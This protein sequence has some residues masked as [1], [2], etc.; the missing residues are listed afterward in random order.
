MVPTSEASSAT[1]HESGVLSTVRRV[2][3]TRKRIWWL[4]S[5]VTGALGGMVAER[6]IR[7]FYRLVRKRSPDSV[8]DLDRKGFSW[9]QFV[10]WAAVGGV[11]IGAAK[12]AS[13]H[14]A[15]VGWKMAT[16]TEPPKPA[17]Q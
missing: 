10:L 4:E 16:G 5:T 15:H 6:L 14:V 7:A 1:H 2:L 3:V 11:C 8:F 17:A 13:R 9:P 12:V